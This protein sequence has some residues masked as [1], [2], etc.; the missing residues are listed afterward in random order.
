MW[1]KTYNKTFPGAN[2]QAVWQVLTDIN[3]WPSWH[4]D[5]DSC[6][7]E[8]PFKV[9]SHFML[10]PKGMSAVKIMITAIE[11]ERRFSDCTNFFGARMPHTFLLEDTPQGLKISSTLEAYGWLSWLWIKLVAQHVAD[12]V[13]EELEMLVQRSKRVR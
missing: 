8:G 10:K 2:K 12:S 9:G 3:Q 11:P 7:L 1:K 5:L 4:G 6:V 13:S